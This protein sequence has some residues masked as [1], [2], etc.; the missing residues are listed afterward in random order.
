[1]NP[2]EPPSGGPILACALDTREFCLANALANCQELHFRAMSDEFS[3]DVF[4]S[5]YS[6]D[7]HVL[8]PPTEPLRQDSVK[9]W[10]DQMPS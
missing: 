7:K 3:R 9:V 8:C 4:L 10:S 1:M 6:K 5:H 2:L